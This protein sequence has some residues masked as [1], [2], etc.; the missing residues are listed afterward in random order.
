MLIA[1]L[2]LKTDS[3]GHCRQWPNPPIPETPGSGLQWRNAQ[4]NIRVSQIQILI[5]ILFQA[6]A[7]ALGLTLC[8]L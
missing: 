8:L 4:R 5:D 1:T 7:S 6:N 3:E 2:L